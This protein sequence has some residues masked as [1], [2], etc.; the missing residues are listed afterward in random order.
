MIVIVNCNLDNITPLIMPSV[1]DENNKWNC[2]IIIRKEYDVKYNNITW[3][4]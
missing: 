2:K 4:I 1:T 3:M